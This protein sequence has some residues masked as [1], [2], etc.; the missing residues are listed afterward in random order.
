MIVPPKAVRGSS[1]RLGMSLIEVLVAA[2]MLFLLGLS[3]SE[4]A[5]KAMIQGV[6]D[7]DHAMAR[8]RLDQEMAE[9]LATE[10]Y[11]SLTP[12]GPPPPDPKEDDLTAATLHKDEVDVL[13]NNRF[14]AA[15][16]DDL[17]GR[18]GLWVEDKQDTGLP[19][20]GPVNYRRVTLILFWTGVHVEPRPQQA[21]LDWDIY[22]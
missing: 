4:F 3:A 10:T 7:G 5:S 6:A 15:V 1:R 14:T 19:D 11:A 16:T 8:L 12:T 17:R 22:E 21:R 9:L 2:T 13:I 20:T 18:I